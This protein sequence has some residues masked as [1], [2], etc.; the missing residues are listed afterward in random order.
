MNPL[1]YGKLIEQI[2]N[3]YIMQLNTQ[4][5]A[6]IEKIDNENF[7]KIFKKGELMF[8]YKEFK[9]SEYRFIRTIQDKRYTFQ[10]NK[11]IS[12]E[13]LSTASRIK[14]YDDTEALLTRFTP[15]NMK[16]LFKHTDI[17]KKAELFFIFTVYLIFWVIFPDD[18]IN[19][20]A[21]GFSMKN[22]IKLRKTTS[23]N[24]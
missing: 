15:F 1:E 17:Y 22:I 21:V 12:T 18:A 7:V 19:V 13:I 5:I 6:I 14:F 3:K 8:E 23:L 2:G 24:I 11:L 9:K 10:N 4:N 20:S 16:S